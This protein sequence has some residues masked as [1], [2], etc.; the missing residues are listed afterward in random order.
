ML[1]TVLT[2]AVAS[3][4]FAN[5]PEQL[6]Q[7]EPDAGEWQ[8]EY[9]TLLGDEGS[10]HLIEFLYGVNEKLALGFEV[11]GEWEDGDLSFE[12][13]GLVALYRVSDPQ[14]DPIGLGFE[15]EAAFDDEVSLS[16][17]EGR[18]ILENITEK[19]WTQADLI[20]RHAREAGEGGTGLAYGTAINR[21]LGE[22]LWLGIEASG[23]LAR[24]GGNPELA[25][26][27]QHYLGPALTVERDVGSDGEVEI[28]LAYLARIAGEG[29]GSAVRIFVQFGF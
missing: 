3:P 4:A 2:G 7:L 24:L 25:P 10:E 18:V 9:F 5:G 27:G 8:A 23:Q 12:E 1:G 6:D 28:G 20:V 22:D 21:S 11:E 19:W 15:A 29:P 26:E 17:A 16:E 13:F 14:D